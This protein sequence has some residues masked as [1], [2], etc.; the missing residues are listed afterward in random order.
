MLERARLHYLSATNAMTNGDSVRSAEQFEEAISILNELSYYP[1]IEANQDFNDLSNAVIEDYE[2]YI[3]RIDSLSPETSIFAL[4]AK[5]NQLT[6]LADSPDAALPTRI[7][8]ASTL[9]LVV[10]G[11]VEQ[12]IAFFQGRGR[13]HMERWLSRAGKYFPMMLKVFKEEGVPEEVVFLSMVE[14]GLNPRARSWARAVGLWQF[15][16]GTGNLYGLRGNYWYDER[17][18]FEKSTRAAARH[19]RDLREEFGDWYLALAAYNSGAGRIYRGIRRSGST[20]FWAMRKHLPRETRNYVPQYIA[21]T[22]IGMDPEAYGFSGIVPEPP[23]E[24]EYV[25]VDDCVDLEVLATCAGTTADVLHDLNPELLQWCTPPGARGYQLRV[26]VGGAEG[27]AERYA[28]IPDDQKRDWLV[29]TVRKGET[30]GGIAA[31]YGISQGILMETNKISSPRSLSVGRSLVIPVPRGAYAAATLAGPAQPSGR[32]SRTRRPTQAR[33]KQ[34]LAQSRAQ[35]PPDKD[36]KASLEYKV[37]KGDTIG[38][39]AEW[40][41]VRASDIRNWND[42]AYGRHILAGAT[43][44]IW[45]DKEDV[46]RYEKINTLSFSDK[47]ALRKKPAPVR[48]DAAPEGSVQYLVK[49]GDTLEKIAKEHDVSITQLKLWNNL[50]TSRIFAGQMLV[51]YPEA[52]QVRVPSRAQEAT[53]QGDRDDGTIVY[54]VKKGDTLYDIAKAHNVSTAQ[55]KKWNAIARTTIYEGQE[56]VIRPAGTELAGTG[57]Q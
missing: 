41:G 56:L 4:R 26:P 7:V 57:N 45:V 54:V 52:R 2:V 16:K 13:E 32:S 9:P 51:V 14:S 50:R 18:D 3:A 33:V 10:N 24:Y 53:S 44:T 17:R 28:A 55:L 11:L 1:G 34:A 38:H 37:K 47:E 36:K 12:N 35:T 5:L 22:L 27:F 20:D 40:F 25:T 46:G 19:L 15:I 29:H 31:K 30:I 43:L 49:S 23:L 8:Q 21:V 48:D 6:D 39:I 42:L